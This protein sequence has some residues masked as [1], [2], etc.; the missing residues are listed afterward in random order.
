MFRRALSE[1][2]YRRIGTPHQPVGAIIDRP[3]AEIDYIK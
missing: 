3:A 1:R 2:P